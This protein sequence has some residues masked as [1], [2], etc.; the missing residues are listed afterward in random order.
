MFWITERRIYMSNKCYFLSAIFFCY[1]LV[2]FLLLFFVAIFVAI[3]LVLFFFYFLVLFGH[4][5]W[6]N[7]QILFN[8]WKYLKNIYISKNTFIFLNIQFKNNIFKL[9]QSILKN[10]TYYQYIEHRVKTVLRRTREHTLNTFYVYINTWYIPC[11]IYI[12][13]M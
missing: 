11:I 5:S 6:C 1:F 12:H 4:I 8:I 2:L 7:N 9:K 10:K 3:F 13:G